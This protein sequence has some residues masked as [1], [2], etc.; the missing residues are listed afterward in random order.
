MAVRTNWITGQEGPW[1]GS[2]S[3]V[4][5]RD[6]EAHCRDRGTCWKDNHLSSTPWIR[7]LWSGKTEGTPGS[8]RQVTVRSESDKWNLKDRWERGKRF[9]GLIELFGQH[10]KRYVWR[11]LVRTNAS[12]YREVLEENLLQSSHDLHLILILKNKATVC[13][14][15]SCPIKH[16]VTRPIFFLAV[17]NFSCNSWIIKE[18]IQI[19]F[20][21][22]WRW[23]F[24]YLKILSY[25]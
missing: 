5:R 24:P 16:C 15:W 1:S 11:R 8:K 3:A 20:L 12:K 17:D 7:P 22:S 18:I 10:H 13:V 4:T 25:I 21:N 9:S 2:N 23:H 6:S 19:V 14:T